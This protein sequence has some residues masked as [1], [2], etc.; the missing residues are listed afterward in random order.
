M[1]NFLQRETSRQC[2]KIEFLGEGTTDDAG[3]FR[4]SLI[5]IARELEDGVLPLLTKSP[6]NRNEHGT[7][8]ECFILNPSSISPSHLEMYRFLGGLVGYGIM[9]RSPIPINFAP[10]LWK[11]I[12]GVELTLSDLDTIDAYSCQVLKDL[13]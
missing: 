8:R 7:H 13:K 5:Y 6:N 12:L 11:Q 3:P 10:F 1:S 2:W 4:D 9:S